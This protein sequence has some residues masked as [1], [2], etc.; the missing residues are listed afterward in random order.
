MAGFLRILS[1]T[2]FI[3]RQRFS[4]FVYYKAIGFRTDRQIN[5]REGIFI[6]IQSET[7]VPSSW[8]LQVSV[9]QARGQQLVTA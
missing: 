4:L 7:L 3:L 9:R 6:R 5:R 1:K 2:Q 8:E